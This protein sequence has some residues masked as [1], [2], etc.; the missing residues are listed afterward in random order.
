MDLA[1][2]PVPAPWESHPCCFLSLFYSLLDA[3]GDSGALPVQGVAGRGGL[4]MAG[5]VR[6]FFLTVP[7]VCLPAS[8]PA[9]LEWKIVYIGSAESTDYDQEL[10]C[11]EVGPVPVGIHKFVMEVRRLWWC[12]R[13][14]CVLARTTAYRCMQGGKGMVVQSWPPIPSLS[15]LSFVVAL[16]PLLAAPDTT[17]R[18]E[19][20]S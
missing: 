13:I 2:T 9:D 4:Q 14:L 18:A 16:W 1:H 12:V 15:C 11:V 10:A 6:V 20:D 5:L 7:C 3:S 19:Q 8:H 17:T